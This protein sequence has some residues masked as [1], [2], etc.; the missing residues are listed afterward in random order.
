M[1]ISG[2]RDENTYQ[3]VIQWGSLGLNIK[4][5]LANFRLIVSGGLVANT[6]LQNNEPWSLG[7]YIDEIG[8]VSAR[9]KKTFG[10]Y[11]ITED[12]DDEEQEVVSDI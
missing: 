2:F 10:I 9:C 8:G 11:L 12:D 5:S 4:G 3:D 6:Q 1:Q 7:G